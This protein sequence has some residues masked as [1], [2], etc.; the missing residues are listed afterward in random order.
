MLYVPVPPRSLVRLARILGYSPTALGTDVLL[1]RDD[2]TRVEEL[3][4]CT[5][6]VTAAGAPRRKAIRIGTPRARTHLVT[7]EKAAYRQNGRVQRNLASWLGLSQLARTLDALGVNCVLD[8]GANKGQFAQR[9]RA[10]GYRGRIVSFE[11]VKEFVAALEEASANDDAWRV[12]PFALGEEDTET[13]I[14]VAKGPLSSLLPSSEFGKDWNA[15]LRETHPETISVRRLDGV[16]DEAVADL[17]DPR[18]FL[19]L[20][21]QGFD[22]QAFRGA[23]GR[24]KDVL[25]LQ[26]ELSCVP[27]YQ[28]MPRFTE[29]IAEYEAAGFELAGLYP[30]TLHPETLRVIEF[31]AI[32][33]RPDEVVSHQSVAG[34]R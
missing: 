26:S 6:L 30:L 3:D 23:G 34:S 8:V 5:W 4:D 24:A 12:Q 17:E 2:R 14:N 28:G 25:G 32:M 21:T 11:P 7:H 22:V 27:I 1:Y 15:K 10:A 13:E 33:V 9:I 19:K 29:Q 31:D 16:F 20:D 18:V